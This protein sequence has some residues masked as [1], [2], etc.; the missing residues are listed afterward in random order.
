MDKFFD[1]GSFEVYLN[2][3]KGFCQISQ[4]C[5]LL[6]KNLGKYVEST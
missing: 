1:Y 5:L 3:I 6:Q 2:A 4:W